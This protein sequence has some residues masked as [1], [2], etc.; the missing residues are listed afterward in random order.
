MDEHSTNYYKE[1]YA[2]DIYKANQYGL[3]LLLGILILSFL[4]FFLVWPDTFWSKLKG[5]FAVD[6]V[7]DFLTGL[8]KVLVILALGITAHEFIHGV[9][10]AFFTKRGFRSIR[11]GILKQY[12]TPYCHSKEPLKV[13]QYITGAVMPAVLLGFLPIILSIVAGSMSWLIF[14][15]FFTAAAGGDFI[16]I[17]ML[18]REPMTAWVEDHASEAGYFMYRENTKNNDAN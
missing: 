9:F 2:I 17:R 5:L 1:K 7:L 8:G 12:L 14:G 18:I 11:F 4:L 6:G 15:I 13:W 10:W 3:R 16:M